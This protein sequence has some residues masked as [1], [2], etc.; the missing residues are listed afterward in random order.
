VRLIGEGSP[1]DPA[2][3]DPGGIVILLAGAAGIGRALMSWRRPER[4]FLVAAVVLTTLFF[5]ASMK[6]VYHYHFALV[7]IL[8]VPLIAALVDELMGRFRPDWQ[9]GP[10]SNRGAVVVISLLALS[11]AVS[12]FASI[13][14]GKELDRAYQDR[15]MRE[16]HLR[17]VAG[18][19]VWSGIPWALHREPAYHFWFLPELTRHLVRHEGAAPYALGDAVNDPPAAVVFDHNAL[20]WVATV[21]R[22][23]APYLVRH[24]VPV[25]RNLWLP[26]MNGVVPAGEA[27]E[28]IV[29]RDGD[30][31]IH[32]DSALADHLWFRDPLLVARHH[33]ADAAQFTLALPSPGNP[34]GLHWLV[35]GEAAEASRSLILQKGQVLSVVNGR[36]DAIAVI[37]YPDRDT[38]LFRQPPPGVTLEGETARITH[39]PRFGAKIE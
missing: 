22:E 34:R 36:P 12:S 4:R 14:R 23:L 7:V 5:I 16:V 1:F 19:S 13:F 32:S 38:V 26:G 8:L 33:G 6:F 30:Y 2:R 10:G 18:E 3:V 25:W 39:W 27:R 9:P 21:Q 11:L 17:T 28:W 20:V 35:D 29:P 37:L 24:Y 15:I 31:A